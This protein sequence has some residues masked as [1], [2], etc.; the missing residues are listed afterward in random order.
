V[1]AFMGIP[2][3]KETPIMRPIGIHRTSA[4]AFRATA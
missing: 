3:W 4:A 2:A 1:G